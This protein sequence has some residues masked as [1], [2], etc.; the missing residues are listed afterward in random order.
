MSAVE[1]LRMLAMGE[2]PAAGLLHTVRLESFG[3]EAYGEEAVVESFRGSPFELSDTAITIKTPGYVA[4]FDG[5]TALIADLYGDNIARIWRL[6]DGDA[7][8]G[9]A[10]VSVVFDPDL[11]QARGDLFLAAS[12]HPAL[13][14][15][16]VDRAVAAGRAINRENAESYRTRA[17]AIRAFGTADEGVA[18][19]AVY[20]LAGEPARTSGF[21]MAA[22]H[23][24][25]DNLQI[26]RDLAGEQSVAKRLWT[27]RIEK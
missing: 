2:R 3:V 20:R 13:E 16:A 4:V 26:V 21:V 14:A 8:D 9:E 1:T 27:P 12:D 22:A 6:G 7:R 17:F 5:S 24:T 19:F 25:A 18:L 10:G 15:N 11:A 23:W